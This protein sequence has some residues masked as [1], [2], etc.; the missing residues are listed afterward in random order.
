MQLFDRLGYAMISAFFGAVVGIAGWWLYG[1]THSL[2]YTGPAMDP[3]LRHWLVCSTSVF[4][5]LGFFFKDTAADF[6]ADAVSAIVHF[7]FNEASGN[8]ARYGVSLV[9]IALCIAA[10]WFTT[11][12]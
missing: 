4:A 9:F 7:E 6:L 12:S 1:L 3:V 10:I 8:A 2:N 5:A 11:P